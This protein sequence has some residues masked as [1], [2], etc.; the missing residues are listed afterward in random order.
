MRELA[1]DHVAERIDDSGYLERLGQLRSDLAT[2]DA[3]PRGDLPAKRAVEWLRI[4]AETWVQAD[5][6]EA[7]ADLLHAMYD[8]IVVVGP[9]I[10]SA[11][12]SPAAYSNGLALALPEVV[13]ARPEGTGRTPPTFVF[14]GVEE[15]VEVLLAA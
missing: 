6:P 7:R 13:M 15:L 5:V 11:S 10:V 12:L 4:L 9:S 2:V 3:T 8:R 14:E 1:L